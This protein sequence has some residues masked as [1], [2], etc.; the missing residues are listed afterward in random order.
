MQDTAEITLTEAHERS[1]FET[2][3]M[4]LIGLALTT[5]GVKTGWASET[6][7]YTQLIM[8]SFGTVFTTVP[9]RCFSVTDRRSDWSLATISASGLVLIAFAVSAFAYAQLVSAFAPL[10]YNP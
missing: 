3:L 4:T 5:V 1:G 10:P 2:L 9:R 7:G 6:H 8:L